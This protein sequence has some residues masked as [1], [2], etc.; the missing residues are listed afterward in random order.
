[1]KVL[2]SCFLAILL[3]LSLAMSSF[4]W[5]L[6]WDASTG[7]VD[8]YLLSYGI[9]GAGTTEI[10]VGD[11]LVYDLDSLGLTIGERYEFFL[12]AHNVTGNSGESDHLRWTAIGDPIIIEMAGQPLNILINP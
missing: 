1:M 9:V 4:A 3:F 11:V 12:K 2:K 8:G 5:Q 7:T 6:T 10:D